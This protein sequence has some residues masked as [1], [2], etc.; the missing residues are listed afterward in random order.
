MS[1]IRL[2]NPDLAVVPSTSG[3]I[4]IYTPI[5]SEFLD[6]GLL[7]SD[8]I[9]SEKLTRIMDGVIDQLGI[10]W[11]SDPR[12]WDPLDRGLGGSVFI[13]NFWQSVE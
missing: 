12:Y 11:A 1:E 7:D 2:H 5:I 13:S 3:S 9:P 4:E 8:N 6:V 10:T